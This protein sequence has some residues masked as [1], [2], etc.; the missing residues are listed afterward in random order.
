MASSDGEFRASN[1]C[2]SL[3]PFREMERYFCGCEIQEQGRE[4]EKKKRRDVLSRRAA[5]REEA[6][7]GRPR[8]WGNGADEDETL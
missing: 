1:G 7:G 2:E 6:T 4:R 3:P 5:D 8:D